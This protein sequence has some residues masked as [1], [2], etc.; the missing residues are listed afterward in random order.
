MDDE[1]DVTA[2]FQVNFPRQ[3]TENSLEKEEGDDFI[4]STVNSICVIQMKQDKN[5]DKSCVRKGILLLSDHY[6]DFI[7]VAYQERNQKN[8]FR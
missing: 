6:N 7:C 3:E 1:N 5:Y 8:R 4:L 2:R